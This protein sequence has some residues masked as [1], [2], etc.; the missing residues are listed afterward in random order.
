M[1]KTDPLPDR[2]D[3]PHHAGDAPAGT[4]D[5]RRRLIKGALA[6]GPILMTLASRPVLGQTG[7]NCR[8]PSGFASG[9]VSQNAKTVDC[10]GFSP[11]YWKQRLDAW[12]S[13]PF[14]PTTTGGSDGSG[15]SMLSGTASGSD[16]HEATPFHS[17]TTGFGGAYFGSKTM[18]QV[19]NTGGG[20]LTALGRH[21]CASLLNA[22]KFPAESPVS[23]TVVRQM[24]NDCLNLGYFEPIA[25]VKWNADAVCDYL[26]SIYL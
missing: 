8:T 16:V 24:W 23:A 18:L 9:N 2:P 13:P 26:T 14:Y 15:P 7:G 19:L 11:G 1:K 17:P 6:A 5:S 21:V 22:T 25:G 20:G 3:S 10:A 12:P 4:L